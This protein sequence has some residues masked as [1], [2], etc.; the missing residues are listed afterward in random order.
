MRFLNKNE[1]PMKKR[2]KKKRGKADKAAGEPMVPARRV[3]FS[4]P[5]LALKFGV[6][7]SFAAAGLGLGLYVFIADVPARISA[8]AEQNIATL[9][10]ET[11]FVLRE[12]YVVGRSETDR[13]D[14]LAAIG[15][16]EGDPLLTFD[17]EAARERLESLGWVKT[18]EVRR[19]LPDAITVR[20]EEREALA[21]W[22]QDHIHVL[23]DPAGIVIGPQDVHRHRHL[24][25]LVGPDAPQHAA[26]LLT[27]LA[28]EPELLDRVLAAQRVGQ[29]RWNLHLESGIHVSLPEEGVAAA[30]R[31]L[32]E[33]QRDHEIL[34]RAVGTIDLR[35]RDRITVRLTEPGLKEV[36]DRGSQG[37]ET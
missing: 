27:L 6:G 4:K 22:Q 30:W 13:E 33:Y 36:Q 1:P 32:A 9:T 29:R 24:K 37:Q 18:A 34:S 26:E 19:V 14:V 17:P 3:G 7:A 12:V 10:Q 35:Q 28:N 2:G 23:I 31:L 20:L 21:I 16:T 8:W 25:V 15:L 5:L 11:G